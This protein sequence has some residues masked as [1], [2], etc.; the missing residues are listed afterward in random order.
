MLKTSGDGQSWYYN[1]DLP[2]ALSV[3]VLDANTRPVPGVRVDWTSTLGS[4]TLTPSADTT[5]AAGVSETVL[6]LA[7]AT[8][9][10]V[11]ANVSGIPSV[12]FAAT[13]DAPP[14]TAAVSVKDNFFMPDSVVVQVNDTVFWTWAGTQQHNVTFGPGQ[15]SAN[16]TS[17]SYNRVFPNVGKFGYTCTI[18]AGMKGVVVVV[19]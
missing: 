4:G 1:N 6:T 11:T 18:H 15:A 5:D 13:A 8:T 3:T 10:V 12:T 19:H 9:Y 2:V 17:G 16:Q 14:A 7:S